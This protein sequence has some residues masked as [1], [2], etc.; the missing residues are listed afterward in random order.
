MDTASA[1][2]DKVDQDG[3]EDEDDD[4]VPT[5]ENCDREAG[6]ENDIPC[7]LAYF[8]SVEEVLCSRCFRHW[9]VFGVHWPDRMRLVE[10]ESEEPEVPEE[11]P[12][13]QCS[14]PIVPKEIFSTW[15]KATKIKYI[16]THTGGTVPKEA[17]AGTI[18]WVDPDSPRQCIWWAALVSDA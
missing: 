3:D 11:P 18:V 8:Y 6:I 12:Q 9:S 17:V 14:F 2:K 1:P 10:S 16:S 15:D 13:P 7:S 4:A 5:C